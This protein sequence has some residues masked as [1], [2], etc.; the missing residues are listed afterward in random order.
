MEV[1][2]GVKMS[3]DGLSASAD[4][5]SILTALEGKWLKEGGGEADTLMIP[6]GGDGRKTGAT[7]NSVLWAV[8]VFAV[9]GEKKLV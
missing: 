2:Y 9:D 7:L 1:K 4:V 3:P 5:H 8:K 6:V